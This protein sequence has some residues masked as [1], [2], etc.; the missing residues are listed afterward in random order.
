MPKEQETLQSLTYSVDEAA[1]L[2]GIGRN[3]AYEGIRRGEI[4]SI[5]VMRCRRVPKAALHR[6]LEEGQS[7]KSSKAA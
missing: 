7:A 4:P 3:T 5:R 6:M 2:L 1:I